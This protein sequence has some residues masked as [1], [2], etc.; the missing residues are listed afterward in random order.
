MMGSK[1]M[2]ISL[3]YNITQ[4]MNSVRA[5]SR[6]ANAYSLLGEGQAL[7]LWLADGPEGCSACRSP[8]TQNRVDNQDLPMM[9]PD[10]VQTTQIAS[11]V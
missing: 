10:A 7:M 3:A 5:E 11:D 4:G 9:K 8:S 1:P 2:V 6:Q